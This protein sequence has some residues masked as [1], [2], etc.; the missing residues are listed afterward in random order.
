M[1]TRTTLGHTGRPLKAGRAETAMYLLLQTGAIV[2]LCANM[3]FAV[4]SATLRQASLVLAAGLW[5][6]AFLLYLVVYAP[7]LCNARLDGREG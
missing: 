1:I 3:Q 6:T 7:Y 2:R 5:S 4:Q